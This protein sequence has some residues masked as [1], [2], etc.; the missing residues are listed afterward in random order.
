MR[1]VAPIFLFPLASKND[2]IFNKR[3]GPL[4]PKIVEMHGFVPPPPQTP[5]SG[6]R[7]D[8]WSENLFLYWPLKA[9]FSMRLLRRVILVIFNT[10][11]TQTCIHYTIQT[12]DYTI[13]NTL[14]TLQTTH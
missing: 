4:F 7:G 3:G 9:Q 6:C 2:T 10:H 8:P 1:I 12:N 13:H 14:F 11:Y 5:I